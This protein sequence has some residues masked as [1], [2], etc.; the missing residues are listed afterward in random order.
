MRVISMEMGAD[1]VGVFARFVDLCN[2]VESAMQKATGT[3]FAHSKHLGYILTCPSNLGT[4]LRASMMI[5]L[6]LVGALGVLRS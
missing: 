1:I 5:K 4:G 6:P 2:N 3:K